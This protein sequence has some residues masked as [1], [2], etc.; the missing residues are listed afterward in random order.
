MVN[1]KLVQVLQRHHA[2]QKELI[3]R[4]KFTLLLMVDG[5]PREQSVNKSYILSHK[6]CGFFIILFV[7]LSAAKNFPEQLNLF[8]LHLLN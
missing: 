6:F 1:L 3:G 2:R 5:H 8:S 7:I 4:H